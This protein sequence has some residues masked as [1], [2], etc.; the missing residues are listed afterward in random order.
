MLSP[1]GKDMKGSISKNNAF[2]RNLLNKIFLS[3]VGGGTSPT[4]VGSK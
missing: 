2:L 4:V 1:G 3:S